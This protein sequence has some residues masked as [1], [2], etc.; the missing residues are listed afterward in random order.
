MT[1]DL[2]L[3]RRTESAALSLLLCFWRRPEPGG[4]LVAESVGGQHCEILLG[5][6]VEVQAERQSLEVYAVGGDPRPADSLRNPRSGLAQPDCGHPKAAVRSES[7]A[8]VILV[9][10]GENR[11]YLYKNGQVAQTYDVAT[12]RPEFPTPTGQF[13]VV[14]KQTNP[15]WH[16]PHS[17]WSTSIRPRQE[18]YCPLIARPSPRAV[19]VSAVTP[20]CVTSIV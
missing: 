19:P 2:P 18:R 14:S 11:L 13:S 16:N 1:N 4:F 17:S 7:F 6:A 3:K 10:T 12:G 20:G 9:R 15:T 5:G 8:T